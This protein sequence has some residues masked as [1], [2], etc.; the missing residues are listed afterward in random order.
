MLSV[1][2][3]SG[4]GVGAAAKK[5]ADR[6]VK[7]GG[8][9]QNAAEF[10]A[11][12]SKDGNVNYILVPIVDT[13]LCRELL[14]WFV[15]INKV[16]GTMQVHDVMLGKPG[17]SI[18]VRRI[19]CYKPCCWDRDNLKAVMPQGNCQTSITSVN[20]LWTECVLYDAKVRKE[21]KEKKK[22]IDKQKALDKKKVS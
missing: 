15:T 9:I 22:A 2:I 16:K 18:L 3:F 17:D 10:V 6:F 20:A 11:H 14:Q 12:N 1:Y 5:K 7:A 8:N 19:A 21:L 4:D 13:Y